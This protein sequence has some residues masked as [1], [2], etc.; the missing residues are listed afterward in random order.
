MSELSNSNK[1]IKQGGCLSA[2]LALGF[3]VA[4]AYASLQGDRLNRL[5]ME[6]LP[7][8]RVDIQRVFGGRLGVAK[9]A[10]ALVLSSGAALDLIWMTLPWHLDLEASILGRAELLG[11]D[12]EGFDLEGS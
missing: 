11:V 4:L 5:N 1:Q 9:A 7:R 12:L 2:F 6:F 3:G 8:I 10:A